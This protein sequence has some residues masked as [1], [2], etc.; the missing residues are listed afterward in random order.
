MSSQPN[1]TMDR[2]QC[3][4]PS[5]SLRFWWIPWWAY[6]GHKQRGQKHKP[7]TSLFMVGV[8]RFELVASSVS[9]ITNIYSVS[10][11]SAAAKNVLP[12]HRASVPNRKHL[13]H[14]DLI[15]YVAEDAVIA[16]SITPF[17]RTICRQPFAICTRVLAALQ[18][19]AYPGG[20]EP[21]VETVHFLQLF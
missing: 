13:D 5:T 11:I 3:S 4:W 21:C 12:I 14:E 17:T 2:I 20:D 9:A 16:H 19:L 15:L 18:I 6:G 10:V 1:L 7:L 8:T